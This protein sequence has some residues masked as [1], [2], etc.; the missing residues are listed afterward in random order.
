MSIAEKLTTIAENEQRVY[1]S[2]YDKAER[3]KELK[4]WEILSGNGTR[5]RYEKCF[6]S[7]SFPKDYT[8][9]KPI[10]PNYCTQMFYDMKGQFPKNIDLSNVKPSNMTTSNE[11]NQNSGLFAWSVNATYLYDMGLQAPGVYF[12]TWSYCKALKTIEKI[13]VT[14]ST[15][16]S[17]SSIGPPFEQCGALENVT[18]EGEI[19]Q[20]LSMSSCS[21]LTYESLSNIISCLYDYS[22]EGVTKTL[23]LHATAKARLTEDDIKTITDKGWTLV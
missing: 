8:F 7:A 19:G 5:I 17:G 21:K 9:A 4:I 14:K 15:K 23:T 20:N 2:G 6:Y 1:D 16:F 18:F 11:S 22:A 12:S 3:D 13:R 10:V